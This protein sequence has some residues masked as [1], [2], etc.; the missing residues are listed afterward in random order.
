M[1]HSKKKLYGEASEDV[2]ECVILLGA[3]RNGE[4]M[5][6]QRSPGKYV[7]QQHHAL[8]TH[9]AAPPGANI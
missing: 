4:C 3:L 9:F 1:H 7:K 5:W 6:I 2:S 8:K